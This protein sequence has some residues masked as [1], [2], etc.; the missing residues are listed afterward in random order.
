MTPRAPQTN[1]PPR[2][3]AKRALERRDELIKKYVDEGLT[4]A[5]A[6]A[7]AQVELLDNPKR[8]WRSG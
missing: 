3:R 2:R 1:H 8:D 4:E 5:E 7:R 6:E